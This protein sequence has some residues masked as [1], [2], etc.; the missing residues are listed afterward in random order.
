VSAIVVACYNLG[1]NHENA[2]QFGPSG[3]F[4]K[5]NSNSQNTF[6]RN[7]PDNGA[8]LHQAWLQVLGTFTSVAIAIIFGVI[9]GQII[10]CFYSERK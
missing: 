5:I 6:G 2:N 8:F 4:S 9:A 7:T 10:N 1:Y 3:L